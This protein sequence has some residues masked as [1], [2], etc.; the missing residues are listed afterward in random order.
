MKRGKKAEYDSRYLLYQGICRFGICLFLYIFLFFAHAMLQ[1]GG[2]SMYYGTSTKIQYKAAP[3]TGNNSALLYTTTARPV[4]ALSESCSRKIAALE[5]S[6]RQ[7]TGKKIA[8]I[9]YQL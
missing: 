1:K 9:A 2:I 4:A 6:I 5:E 8:L 7:E 3:T